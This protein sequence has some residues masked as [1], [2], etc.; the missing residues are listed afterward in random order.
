MQLHCYLNLHSSLSEHYKVR[1]APL[2][3][4]ELMLSNRQ[5]FVQAVYGTTLQRVVVLSMVLKRQLF[6]LQFLRRH[7]LR[8]D[9][10]S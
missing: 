3:F 4:R 10:L 6:P 8:N 9:M 5:D 1:S 7:T 2:G